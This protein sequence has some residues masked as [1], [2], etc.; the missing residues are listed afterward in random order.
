MD[1]IAGIVYPDIFQM[2]DL[3]HPMLMTIQ[4]RGKN[5]SDVATYKN[6][7]VGIIGRKLAANAKKTV[8]AG[9]DGWISNAQ[10]L[11]KELTEEGYALHTQDDSE[12]LICAYEYW[13][14]SV[15]ERL[16]GEFSL[17]ILDQTKKR[18]LLC[19]DRI[20]KKPLYWFHNPYYFMFASE[21]KA[22][23]ATGAVP[24]TPALDALSS[25]LYFGYIPQDMSP[26]EGVS[27]LL[28]A[29]FMQFNFDKSLSINSYWSYSSYFERINRTPLPTVI[30]DLDYLLRR[31][32]TLSLPQ[33]QPV[34]CMLSGGLG[35][36]SVASYMTQATSKDHVTAFT[37][38]FKGQTDKDLKV[39]HDVVEK[40]GIAQETHAIVPS[41]FLQNLV[42]IAWHLDEPMADPNIIATWNLASMASAKTDTVYSGMGSDEL[43]AG[44]SRYSMAERSLKPLRKI[45]R[46][47]LQMGMRALIPLFSLLY[48]PYAFLLLK[49]S[50]TNPWQFDYLRENCIF[51]EKEIKRASPKLSG[52]FDP[53]V[54]L[55]KFHHLHR[56]KST[57]ASYLYFDVKTRLP[58]CYM[59]QY[60]RA[61]AAHALRWRT[62]FLDRYI[63]E[64]MAALPEPELLQEYQA[65][66]YLK[67]LVKGA[68][69]ASI[70]DRPKRTR[71]YFLRD[72]IE[73]KEM[74]EIFRLLVKGKLVE[75]GI[76]ASTWLEGKIHDIG[77]VPK[78]FQYLWSVLLLEIWFR[79]Y[80]HRPIRH[81]PHDIEVK[82][83]LTEEL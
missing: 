1:G 48:K 72:W 78:A 68:L 74:Q 29:H 64:Y 19:R 3:I 17:F 70:V 59:Q 10:D 37:V 56:I 69:P 5:G 61:M 4:H 50:R 27:K 28:P 57:V 18:I 23:L 40:L 67:A 65:G 63:V 52:I 82:E 30:K 80:I 6:I 62:P 51:D 38:G 47:P 45:M 36:A 55:H 60:E 32:M 11:A 24:Q 41:E 12:V 71:Q 83:L 42:K 20:G 79:L 14:T 81:I 46:I 13:G 26:V 21:L 53:E 76:I 22:L 54:F 44:H 2:E 34:G 77:T 35:S 75:E 9:V 25:Y 15:F 49:S 58:D 66:S 7:Q 31:N 43:F 8:F 39:T 33:D 73:K 16:N